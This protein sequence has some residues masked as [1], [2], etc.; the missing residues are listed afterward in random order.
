MEFEEYKTETEHPYTSQINNIRLMYDQNVRPSITNEVVHEEFEEK[1]A[2]LDL[3][4]ADASFR[5]LKLEI[6]QQIKLIKPYD[7][8]RIIQEEYS[9]ILDSLKSINQS[10]ANYSRQKDKKIKQTK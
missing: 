2:H 5:D 3:L 4:L 8:C 10:D 6:N 7:P 9:S 1:L